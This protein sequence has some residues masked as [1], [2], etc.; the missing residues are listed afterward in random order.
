MPPWRMYVTGEDKHLAKSLKQGMKKKKK[1]NKRKA[2]AK[3]K[4]SWRVASCKLSKHAINEGKTSQAFGKQQ[5]RQMI[6]QP[7]TMVNCH[8]VHIQRPIKHWA[9]CIVL[10]IY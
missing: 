6:S 7:K 4:A 8:N 5:Q 2:Q 3:P 1:K 9:T 10:K